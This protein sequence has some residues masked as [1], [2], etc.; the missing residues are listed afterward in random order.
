MIDLRGKLKSKRPPEFIDI[1]MMPPHEK[2]KVYSDNYPLI[3]FRKT[4]LY[5]VRYVPSI[6]E[7]NI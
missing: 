1:V 3:K 2:I 5:F 7:I 4:F 6:T